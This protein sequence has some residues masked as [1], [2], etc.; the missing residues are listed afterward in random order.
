MATERARVAEHIEPAL[1]FFAPTD[2]RLARLEAIIPFGDALDVLF[3]RG[4]AFHLEADVIHASGGNPGFREIGDA[5]GDDHQ[6]DVAV[7]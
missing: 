7:G 1:A 2:D 3:Q 4:N 5:P 6:S